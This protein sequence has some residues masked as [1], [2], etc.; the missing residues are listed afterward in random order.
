MVYFIYIVNP[1]IIG[2]CPEYCFSINITY[3]YGRCHRYF[4]ADTNSKQCSSLFFFNLTIR[5]QPMK[6]QVHSWEQK[7]LQS[8]K[9]L[10]RN[11][12][13]ACLCLQKC[14]CPDHIYFYFILNFIMNCCCAHS[15]LYLHGSVNT[16]IAMGSSYPVVNWKPVIKCLAFIK[17]H[18]QTKR[19]LSMKICL[20]VTI[21]TIQFKV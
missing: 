10:Y 14:L 9:P 8:Q 21:I 18:Q 19:C 4:E 1:S 3:S 15:T 13:L 17:A 12:L 2:P 5:A 6:L 20:L 16:K 11:N 7:A